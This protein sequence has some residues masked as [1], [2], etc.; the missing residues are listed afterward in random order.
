MNDFITRLFNEINELVAVVSTK[1][2]RLN[3]IK[4]EKG[5]KKQ[6][7]VSQ[8]N[9]HYPSVPA[10]NAGLTNNLQAAQTYTDTKIQQN[11]AGF[12]PVSQKAA[13]D[14]VATLDS[15][16]KI[17]GNQL[18]P[19]AISDTFP[20][21]NQAQMLAL[22]AQVGD[23]AIRGDLNKTFVLRVE[24]AS[25]FENWSEILAPNSGVQSIDMNVPLGFQV[26]GGPITNNGTFTLSYQSGYSLPSNLKQSNWDEAYQHATDMGHAGIII[27][28]WSTELE[29]QTPI[30]V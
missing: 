14:G 15:Y 17:P 18:P 7:L 8:D 26:V 22:D 3:D 5:N 21:S 12:I 20:V 24:P 10:V 2:N 19:L 1:L 13:A 16:G 25:I 29:T 9:N 27:P 6:N 23:I 11:N 28:D 4:E 30:I